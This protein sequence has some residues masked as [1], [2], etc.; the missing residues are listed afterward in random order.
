MSIE[1]QILSRLIHDETYA[2]AI[3]PFLEDEYFASRASKNVFSLIKQFETK[4]DR[5]PTISALVV[6]AESKGFDEAAYGEAVDLINTLEK[7]IVTDRQ[8]LI[9][10]TEE[11]C[12]ERALQYAIEQSIVLIQDDKQPRAQIQDLVE[13]ALSVDFSTALGHDFFDDAEQRYDHLH[14]KTP[15]I[16]FDLET[17]NRATKGGLKPKTLNIIMAGCINPK[18]IVRIKY[19][20]KGVSR[21]KEMEASKARELCIEGLPTWIDS[22]KGYVRITEWVEKGMYEEYLVGTESML[23]LSCNK[24]HLLMTPSGWQSVGSIERLNSQGQFIKTRYGFEQANIIKTDMM[25][26]I[27]DPIVE[28]ED[29]A[30]Y[31]DGIVSH[32]TNVGKTLMMC[33]F[34]SA[35]VLA[36]KNVLYITFEMA[37]EEIAARIDANLLDISLDQQDAMPK[38]WFL[39][40]VNEIKSKCGGKII[41][42]EYPNGS[43]HV[44]HIRHLLK[45]LRLKRGFK[46]DIIFVDYLMIMASQRYKHGQIAKHGYYQSVA[47]ELRALGQ[48]ENIPVFSAMQTNR[49]GF[50]DSDA[51]MTQIAGSWD[52]TGDCDWF[53]VVIQPEEMV[54]LGQYVIKQEKSRYANK[55]L[56]RKFVIGVDKGKQ[57][58]YDLDTQPKLTD[59]DSV[60]SEKL[61]D[62]QNEEPDN[63]WRGLT[64]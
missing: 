36:G 63:P 11:Y 44:G 45:E 20:Y 23:T 38:E 35:S 50:A 39:R 43:A 31:A 15:R 7:D 32:N 58:L 54:E 9:D 61:R 19:T 30:Y 13:K 59:F 6:D 12:K 41:V 16:P 14:D 47:Q 49:E 56:M 18:T 57:K 27:I 53:I 24:D 29:H 1:S 8:W 34:A 51:D 62:Q 2:R 33:H 25:I 42:Q 10:K 64:Q 17:F 37:Q 60:T 28:H 21:V 26:P 52:L 5:M 55:D 22:P 48:T 46:P 3:L 40:R 4:Y